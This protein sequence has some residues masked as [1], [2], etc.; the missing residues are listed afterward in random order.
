MVTAQ[1]VSEA[2]TPLWYKGATLAFMVVPFA[3]VVYAVIIRSARLEDILMLIGFYLI[4][5]FGITVG[6]HRLLTHRSF[7]THPVVKALLTIAGSMAI[8][9]GP[10]S[11]VP[12]HLKHHA[13]S[14]AEGDPHSPHRYLNEHSG[15]WE[16]LKGLF[17]A[18]F[19]WMFSGEPADPKR[20]GSWLLEDRDILFVDR[21]FL[22]W[23]TVSLVIPF[24]L[25]G[26]L[27]RVRGEP[28]LDGAFQGLL[29]GGLM[30]VFFVHHFTWSINSICH[31][32]GVRPFKTRGSDRSTNVW[33]LFLST[34]G[35][36]W[37][38][39]H[40]FKPSSA[41]HGFY[42]WQIDFSGYLIRLFERIG[43]AWDVV[44]PDLDEYHRKRES[45]S[46]A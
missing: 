9:G 26:V 10:L 44:R 36:N 22:I 34:L 28:V 43:L 11:W 39:N 42:W 32:F 16:L 19:G 6:F 14:D 3:G 27:A 2:K 8:E 33:W 15:L 24:E 17:H 25:G 41:F 4:T 30:R 38:N 5:A 21:F 23:V 7:G 18:H 12:I 37:H 13:L 31:T 1:V 35:E 46:A 45:F 40:H 29:W 20:Y